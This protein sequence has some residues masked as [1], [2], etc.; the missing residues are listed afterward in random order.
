MLP[1]LHTANKL[2]PFL[3]CAAP[4]GNAFGEAWREKTHRASVDANINIHLYIVA[5]VV[6]EFGLSRAAE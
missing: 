4:L 6:Y 5:A 1:A 2:A 3:G